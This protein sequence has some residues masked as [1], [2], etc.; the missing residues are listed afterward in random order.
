MAGQQ[1]NLEIDLQ[2]GVVRSVQVEIP[3]GA[4]WSPLTYTTFDGS[5]RELVSGSIRRRSLSIPFRHEAVRLV[6]I[7]ED[8][9]QGEA[10]LGSSEDVRVVLR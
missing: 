10:R 3:E 2:P 7:S 5:G 6:V 8:G 4:E 9:L 1:T